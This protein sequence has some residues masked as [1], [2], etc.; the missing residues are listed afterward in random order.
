MPVYIDRDGFPFW[1]NPSPQKPGQ[2]P[3]R[4]I[5]F[6]I[7]DASVNQVFNGRSDEIPVIQKPVPRQAKAEG[8][9]EGSIL[10]VGKY[11]SSLMD[12][13]MLPLDQPKEGTP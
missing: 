9:G 12:A 5:Q 10:T 7:E 8:M 6:M 4:Q 2:I 11:G 1:G 13:F 3:A